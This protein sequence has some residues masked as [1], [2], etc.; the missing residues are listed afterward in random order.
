M[1][2]IEAMKRV[3]DL[4]GISYEY[5]TPVVFGNAVDWFA[6]T[7]YVLASQLIQPEVGLLVFRTECYSTNLNAAATDLLQPKAVPPGFAYWKM[8]P[9]F[10]DGSALDVEN[11]LT[12][13]VNRTHIILDC[14]CFVLSTPGAN[15]YLNLCG[16]LDSTP[17]AVTRSVRT[18]CYGFFMPIKIYEKLHNQ[19]YYPNM[20][21]T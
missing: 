19:F 7:N 16:I 6:A 9:I 21:T 1:L 20:P 5:L 17:D 14:D 3:Q 8:A 10:S 18:T 15:A 2:F 12:D 4:T 11:D 13:Q